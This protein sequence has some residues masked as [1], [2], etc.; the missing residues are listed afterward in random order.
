LDRQIATVTTLMRIA[1]SQAEFE[2][3]FERAFPPPQ[4][5]L[6]LQIEDVV[7]KETS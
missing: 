1:Y 2:Q 3:L 5:R 6:P 4:A 7:G